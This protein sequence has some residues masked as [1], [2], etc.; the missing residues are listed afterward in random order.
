MSSITCVCV[1]VGETFSFVWGDWGVYGVSGIIFTVG[2]WAPV[3]KNRFC[4]SMIL[5]NSSFS[6]LNY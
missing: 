5:F 2:V 3:D 1:G 4:C 6:C